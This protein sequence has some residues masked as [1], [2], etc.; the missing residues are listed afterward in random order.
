MITAHT[1]IANSTLF[2]DLS[3][4]H[5]HFELPGH[6]I[7]AS[8]EEATRVFLDHIF[9][10]KCFLPSAA[11]ACAHVV[12]HFNNN[13]SVYTAWLL[14]AV[15]IADCPNAQLASFCQALGL[16]TNEL[17]KIHTPRQCRNYIESC[18][19]ALLN[20]KDV[21]EVLY[22]INSMTIHDHHLITTVRTY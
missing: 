12:Q 5:Q 19:D 2:S 21:A 11:N 16:T 6:G 20:S 15:L 10:G 8:T 1:D 9:N 14:D 3:S 17:S 22:R 13:L 18:R 7:Q 4:Y